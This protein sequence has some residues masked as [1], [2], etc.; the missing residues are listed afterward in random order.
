MGGIMSDDAVKAAE[1]LKD[2]LEDLNRQATALGA[3]SGFIKWLADVS[4]GLSEIFKS[5]DKALSVFKNL[6]RSI[7]TGQ[8]LW[9]KVNPL[10]ILQELRGGK[11]LVGDIAGTETGAITDEEVA[12]IKK[13]EQAQKA[14]SAEINKSTEARRKA[15]EK[16][17]QEDAQF[18]LDYMNTLDEIDK[19]E[20]QAAS[21]RKLEADAFETDYL[22]AIDA[23]DEAERKAEEKGRIGN[24]VIS[25]DS[26]SRTTN[27]IARIGGQIGG[28]G[29]N[30][31]KQRNSILGK[32][33]EIMKREEINDQG[34]G[35]EV[36]I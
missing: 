8:G 33:L 7:E 1:Q 5:G 34:R 21:R 29:T 25:Q 22:N 2:D 31:D 30:I 26:A 32:M 9:A 6:I 20:R 11:S 18:T 4:G 3:N 23:I 14:L 28:A 36:L 15:K 10:S 12:A 13:K 16:E 24:G 35:G 27:A 17:A 19:A